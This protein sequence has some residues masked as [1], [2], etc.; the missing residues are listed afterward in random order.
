MFCFSQIMSCSLSVKNKTPKVVFHNEQPIVLE[1]IVDSCSIPIVI[2]GSKQEEI[3]ILLGKDFLS[4]IRK[5][6]VYK[7][8][9]TES[10]YDEE[11]SLFLEYNPDFTPMFINSHNMMFYSTHDTSTFSSTL[12]YYHAG[13]METISETYLSWAM[14]PPYALLRTSKSSPFYEIFNMETTQ[15]CVSFEIEEELLFIKPVK[16]GYIAGVFDEDKIREAILQRVESKGEPSYD[17]YLGTFPYTESAYFLKFLFFDQSMKNPTLLTPPF[18]LDDTKVTEVSI[19][20]DGFWDPTETI[21]TNPTSNIIIWV[22][23]N[24]KQYFI[25][26]L[27]ILPSLPHSKTN[28]TMF[29]FDE[30]ELTGNFILDQIKTISFTDSSMGFCLVPNCLD[31]DDSLIE[32]PL[33]L[34]SEETST[35][36]KKQTLTIPSSIGLIKAITINKENALQIITYQEEPQIFYLSEIILSNVQVLHLYEIQFPEIEL[37]SSVEKF[38]FLGEINKW[39]FIMIRNPSQTAPD[40]SWK[41]MKFHTP[42]IENN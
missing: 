10:G 19:P 42:S 30:I 35:G 7:C 37:A 23:P 2:D 4:S 15:P 17:D 34:S 33:V 28:K 27:D 29:E 5:I 36:Y 1:S 18:N 41:I 40:K 14:K 26:N 6:P 20:E 3:F 38:E 21:Y 11:F 9:N 25:Q 12:Q 31:Y 13:E 32:I 39:T 8:T 24:G 16:S 22:H